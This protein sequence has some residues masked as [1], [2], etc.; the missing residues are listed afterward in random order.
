MATW[1]LAAEALPIFGSK[2]YIGQD[3]IDYGTFTASEMSALVSRIVD[4]DPFS[5]WQGSTASDLTTVTL[6]FSFNEGSALIARAVDLIVL[7]NINWKNFVG[8]WS[9]DGIT[10]TTISSLN[11]ADGVANNAETDIIVNPSDITS[12]AKFVRF[13]ILKTITA[14]QRKICGGV[15]VCAGVVQPAGGYSKDRT[16]YRESVRQ[17]E[18]GDKTISR[19]YIMRSA[20]DYEFWGLSF[21]LLNVTSA[22]LLLLRGI[23]R[24]GLPFI[25]IPEPYDNKRNAYLCHFAKPWE[26]GYENEVRSVGHRIPMEVVE[27]GSH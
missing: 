16:K 20:T 18:L 14:N 23:K 21:D 1:N 9:V 12:T 27:V 8:E 24:G 15:I 17:L 6:T 26:H 4:G 25:F 2:N 13:S 22:E 10:W 3:S 19:E 5:Y 7:Q 11:Y